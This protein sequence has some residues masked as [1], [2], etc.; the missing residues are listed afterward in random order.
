MILLRAILLTLLVSFGAFSATCEGSN[1][2]GE[3]ECMEERNISAHPE[4]FERNGLELTVRTRVGHKTYIDELDSEGQKAHRYLLINYYP[5]IDH[6]VLY[7]GYPESPWF[8]I[9][10]AASGVETKVKGHPMLSPD[11][12]RF[13]ISHV[14]LEFND[15]SVLKVYRISGEA[16]ELEFDTTEQDSPLAW[17]PSGTRWATPTELV[18]TKTRLRQTDERAPKPRGRA[19]RVGRFLQHSISGQTEPI[20]TDHWSLAR[21]CSVSVGVWPGYARVPRWKISRACRHA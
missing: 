20:S 18:F 10:N 11:K 15:D 7:A 8:I 2:G 9:L 13:A 16:L 21:Y 3:F 6:V 1:C 19:G 4:L 17:G 12:K 14:D 5:E